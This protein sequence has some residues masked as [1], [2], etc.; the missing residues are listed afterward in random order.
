VC[1][2][3]PS[4]RLAQ[5]I[6]R[7][8]C[9]LAEP[10]PVVIDAFVEVGAEAGGWLVS[11]SD[12]GPLRCPTAHQLPPLVRRAVL[13]TAARISE[14][15]ALEAT[16]LAGD[17]AAV[18][19]AGPEAQRAE[20][21]AAW[22]AGGGRVLADG[23]VA[24]DE[25]GRVE[26]TL[27]G[28]EVRP[29]RQWIDDQP[30][31]WGSARAPIVDLDGWLVEYEFLEPSSIEHEPRGTSVLVI[32]GG[33]SLEQVS[34]GSALA[35]LLRW[36]PVGRRFVSEAEAADLVAWLAALPCYGGPVDDP[37]RLA[38]LLLELSKEM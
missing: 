34:P 23:L 21:L 4:A 7:A 25:R 11:G 30:A 12:F 9:G 24:L 20:L 36:R 13:A 16:A 6:D 18:V 17:D 3:A 38:H 35:Y 37:P 26:P 28:L 31:P 1:V 33:E 19:V 29:G 22:T 27:V 2:Q 14:G 8:L 10:E 15:V 32:P 5:W